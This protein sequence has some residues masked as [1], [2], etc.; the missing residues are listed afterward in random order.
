MTPPDYPYDESLLQWIWQHLEF[1]TRN[2]ATECGQKVDIVEPGEQNK[3]AGPDF[4]G[5]IIR[6]NGV[7][8]HGDVELHIVPEGW[9]RHGHSSSDSYNRVVLHVVYDYGNSSASAFRPDGTRPPLLVLKPALQKPL[10][11]LLERQGVSS[12]RCAS[13]L[14]FI[15]QQAFE[16]QI[17]HAHAEYFEYKVQFLLER[18]KPDLSLP[19]AWRYLFSAGLFH[20]LGIPS[21]RD[22]MEQLHARAIPAV[23][24]LRGIDELANHLMDLA[25]STG[26]GRAIDWTHTG[27]RPASRPRK[28][29]EQAAG[30]LHVIYSM[31]FKTFLD[32]DLSSWNRVINSLPAP[33]CPGRQ[34][35]NILEHTI[36]LPASYLLGDLLFAHKLKRNAYRRWRSIRGGVPYE[37]AAPFKRS[38]FELNRHTRKPGLAHQFKR[39][40]KPGNCHR[41]EVFKKAITS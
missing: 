17:E 22:Q 11:Q 36:Y 31:P 10:R 9:A 35:L 37:V 4:F 41:C 6:I 12:V 24:E 39:Y 8:V 7:E 21:N 1:D 23:E 32:P 25:F 34:M 13:N 2:L 16:Q 38:G 26:G 19:N 15:N 14:Q 5:S 40:C 18:Y 29:A 28:R 20:T 30:F 3:G 33:A 27:M